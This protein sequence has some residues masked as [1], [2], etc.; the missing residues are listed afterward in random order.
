M[1]QF[2]NILEKINIILIAGIILGTEFLISQ[3]SNPATEVKLYLMGILNVILTVAVFFHSRFFGV[4]KK[5]VLFNILAVAFLYVLSTIFW[6]QYP[7]ASIKT[8]LFLITF[9]LFYLNVSYCLDSL[10]KI[11]FILTI[12]IFAFCGVCLFGLIQFAG[13][14]FY[15]WGRVYEL[16]EDMDIL[17]AISSLGNPN[18]FGLFIV[19]LLPIFLAL[20]I[21][22]FRNMIYAAGSLASI[23][24]I[25]VIKYDISIFY[26]NPQEI[27]VELML[28][29][30]LAL[31][32]CIMICIK[33]FLLNKAEKATINIILNISNVF[34]FIVAI[35]ALCFTY[36]RGAYVSVIIE[37][38]LFLLVRKFVFR[39]PLIS[40]QLF[41]TISSFF[42]IFLILYFLWQPFS[43]RIDLAV[44]RLT[45]ST[46]L[47]QQDI[48]IRFHLWQVAINVIRNKFIVGHG[49]GTFMNYFPSEIT[50]KWK[51][52]FPKPDMLV[53]SAHSEYL[54]IMLETG[55]IGL[56]F[57]VLITIRIFYL[58][59][60]L[61]LREKDQNNKYILASILIS[62]IGILFNCLFDSKLRYASSAVPVVIYLGILEFFHRSIFYKSNQRAGAVKKIKMA[63]NVTS[64]ANILIFFIIGVSSIM[65]ILAYIKPIASNVYC[66]FGLIEIRVNPQ[67]PKSSIEYLNKALAFDENNEI[68]LY[69]KLRLQDLMRDYAN[70]EKTALKLLSISPYFKDA[71]QILSNIYINMNRY[72]EGLILNEKSLRVSMPLDSYYMARVNKLLQENKYEEADK[73]LKAN[74]QRISNRSYAN[75]MLGRIAE[76]SKKTDVAAEKFAQAISENKTIAVNYYNFGVSL[77]RQNKIDQGIMA[78]YLAQVID[79]GR[80]T[81][82]HDLWTQVFSRLN[83][84]IMLAPS[85]HPFTK[86]MYIELKLLNGFTQNIENEIASLKG[87]SGIIGRLAEIL[88]AKY[89]YIKQN[90]YTKEQILNFINSN[91]S[92]EIISIALQQS[93]QKLFIHDELQFFIDYIYK[94]TGKGEI[95]NIEL[96]F[97]F[98]NEIGNARIPGGN[99]KIKILL[100]NLTP[101]KFAKVIHF[102]SFGPIGFDMQGKEYNAGEDTSFIFYFQVKNILPLK[103]NCHFE[104]FS[105]TYSYNFR[106]TDFIIDPSLYNKGDVF[107]KKITLQFDKN[108]PSNLYE[109]RFICHI[110]NTEKTY[111]KILGD[112]SGNLSTPLTTITVHGNKNAELENSAYYLYNN[113]LYWEAYK[114]LF[115]ALPQNYKDTDFFY[116][117]LKL[118]TLAVLNKK[119]EFAKA[120]EMS[121][122]LNS[123]DYS[124]YLKKYG[125][126]FFIFKTDILYLKFLLGLEPN[127][128]LQE[129]ID[130]STY[131]GNLS[132][133]ALSDFFTLPEEL[134]KVN[135]IEDGNKFEYLFCFK[136]SNFHLQKK[137]F[138]EKLN[139]AI[140]N[141]SLQSKSFKQDAI[142]FTE[143]ELI[144]LILLNKIDNDLK[145][146]FDEFLKTLFY[147]IKTDPVKWNG[148]NF[149]NIQNILDLFLQSGDRIRAGEL[150]PE[151]PADSNQDKLAKSYYQFYLAYLNNDRN[152]SRKIIE[153]F[154]SLAINDR[155]L[156]TFKIM[157]DIADFKDSYPFLTGVFNISGRQIDLNSRYQCK[158]RMFKIDVLDNSYAILNSYSIKFNI[159]LKSHTF[160]F[161]SPNLCCG[162]YNA[163]GDFIMLHT[164]TF[165]EPVVPGE[166]IEFSD[167]VTVEPELIK[168]IKKNGNNLKISAFSFSDKILP[169]LN[170]NLIK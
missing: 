13:Y 133:S 18:F 5:F 56:I 163:I 104:L 7:S 111:G 48:T 40:K 170:L 92:P 113:T 116:Q 46:N 29:A 132:Y 129:K 81:I 109:L 2:K 55:V 119:E 71:N 33:I 144:S 135:D 103:L 42:L 52:L 150:L 43:R 57:F 35:L 161:Y 54:E 27:N 99:E 78:L 91:A 147:L 34:F 118:K 106:G 45:N 38:I 110:D 146:K 93:C 137:Y 94:Y 139:I 44:F 120:I 65:L 123:Q 151:M 61:L 87:Q 112:I 121:K 142:D 39:Q 1:M 166:I 125:Y 25:F 19:A 16:F 37:I 41:I 15:K 77:F 24:L 17:R 134:L 105:E 76:L 115:Q 60:R 89:L 10:E 122:F 158:D 102:N 148:L 152:S 75:F 164:F 86:I 153:N 21:N 73:F 117:F 127:I 114:N 126:Q 14:D 84:N 107:K 12:L 136:N 138:L 49:I 63:A 100:N 69:T 59:I 165:K 66:N 32:F 169:Y 6:S 101:K 82:G 58:N 128:T 31:C 168:N 96:L 62:L 20:A 79:G 51:D 3:Y 26:S 145:N 74:V 64:P 4:N 154:K 47:K 156:S 68:A 160:N 140:N 143:I 162:F 23:L 97:N 80:K 28:G 167:I 155:Q 8:V 108:I 70:A 30:I 72:N 95:F 159:R 50:E 67:S 11:H 149:S 157:S 22:K 83:P 124:L 130:F 90:G 131:K 53:E 98:I 88:D 141:Y 85:I 36:N 9:L